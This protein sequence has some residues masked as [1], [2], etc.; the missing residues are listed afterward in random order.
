MQYIK[1]LKKNGIIITGKSGMRWSRIV[2]PVLSF[3]F[4]RFFYKRLKEFDGPKNNILSKKDLT[5]LKKKHN[6]KISNLNNL[7]LIKKK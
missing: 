4:K 3:S 6:F 1:M 2:K 7:I 5:L